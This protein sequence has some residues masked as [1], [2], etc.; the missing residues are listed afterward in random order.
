M[1]S[2]GNTFYGARN[3]GAIYQYNR[4]LPKASNE[5]EHI[6]EESQINFDDDE[7]KEDQ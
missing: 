6:D 1:V 7:E 3:D 2:I 5:S 4:P